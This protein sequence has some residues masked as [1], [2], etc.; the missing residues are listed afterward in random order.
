MH[1]NLSQAGRLRVQVLLGLLVCVGIPVATQVFVRGIPLRNDIP[2]INSLI[3]ST[4]AVMSGVYFSRRL[5]SFPGTRQRQHTLPSF[6][7][8]FGIVAAALLL[9]RI[10]YSRAVLAASFFL[11]AIFFSFPGFV[12]RRWEDTLF[13]IIPVGSLED[14]GAIRNV[15]LVPL[16]EPDLPPRTKAAI[17]ADFR[18]DLPAKWERMLA[19]AALA[20]YPVYHVKQLVESLTGRVKIEH[21]SENNLGSLIPN[22]GYRKLK[23]FLDIVAAVIVLPFLIPPLLL[24]ALA[25]KLD[26]PG[27]ALFRQRRVGFGG[28]AFTV[29]KFRTMAWRSEQD[30]GEDGRDAAVTRDGDARITRLGNFLRRY[31]I[32]ELPQ[33]VNILRGEMSWIGPR[34]EAIHLSQWYEA[35]L[36][37]YSYRHIVLPGISG[38]AQVNQGHVADLESV[39]AKLQYDFF[40][41]KNFS[42]WLDLLI[43]FRTIRTMLT[44]FGSK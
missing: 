42:A 17:V 41:I 38:W 10:D 12:G 20:G 34:P 22:L 25:I 37:F 24:V 6:L 35:E 14:L 44:G 40:Y 13:Y 43:T 4:V 26:N 3:A 39:Y 15:S 32:D 29:Y 8:S 31:R 21:L 27:P 33:I 28:K 18:A 23:L 11:S 30:D 2:G 7:L 36:P 19:R 5:N 1:D 16:A 9:F